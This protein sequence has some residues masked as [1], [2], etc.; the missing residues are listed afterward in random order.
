MAK[1][2]QTSLNAARMI[3]DNPLVIEILDDMETAAI[4]SAVQA[5]ITD[6]FKPAAYLAEVRAIRAFR[7][8]LQFIIDETPATLKR[9]E[10]GN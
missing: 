7:S 6:E 9:N 2:D 4:N 1:L 5:N 3:L 10:A 8:R